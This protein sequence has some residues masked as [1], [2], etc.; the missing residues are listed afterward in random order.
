MIRQ[1][2]NA[3][4]IYDIMTVYTAH[5]LK[6]SGVKNGKNYFKFYIGSYLLIQICSL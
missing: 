5:S 3:I 1:I 2:G 6:P 4:E